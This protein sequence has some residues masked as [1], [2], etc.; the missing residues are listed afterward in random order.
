[1]LGLPKGIALYRYEATE[2]EE[3]TL[4]EGDIV[5]IHDEANDGWWKVKKISENEKNEQNIN[6]NNN[7]SNKK[8]E[9][10]FPHN[11]VYKLPTMDFYQLSQ[12]KTCPIQYIQNVLRENQLNNTNNAE[13]NKGDFNF[14]EYNSQ[15]IKDETHLIASLSDPMEKISPPLNT[16]QYQQQQIEEQKQQEELLKLQK[17][18]NDERQ[19]QQGITIKLN[20]VAKEGFLIKKGHIRRNWNVRWFQLKRNILTYSKTPNEPKLSGTIVL[21]SETEI[22]IATNM[23]RTNCFQIKNQGFVFYCSSQSPDDMESWIH[24]LNQA[25]VNII[26]MLFFFFFDS[27]TNF[28]FFQLFFFSECTLI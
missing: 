8:D 7:N 19:K 18:Q 16:D 4:E 23:K 5:D 9:G 2:D 27:Y 21:S 25:K 3:L 14:N 28:F 15:S 24:A 1:F 22:D 13:Q 6:G 10:I 17:E 20:D 12:N 26:I 11:Y